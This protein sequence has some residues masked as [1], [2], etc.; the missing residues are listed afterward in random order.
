[1]TVVRSFLPWYREGFPAGIASDPVV[2]SGRAGLP[3]RFGLRNTAHEQQLPVHLA[4]PADVKGLDPRMIGRTEPYDGCADFEPGYL[5][6]VEFASP[7]LPWRFSPHAARAVT[8]ADPER[9][10]ES[11]T[12][13]RLKPWLALIV[14]ASDRAELS[15]AAPG[16]LPALVTSAELLPPAGESWAWAHVQVTTGSGE[17]LAEAIRDPTRAVARLVCPTR[18]ESLV[19]YSA[20]VVPTYEGGRAVLGLSVGSDPLA[21]SWPETGE[22]TLPVYFQWSFSTGELGTFETLARRLRP[23]SAPRESSGTPIDTGVPGWTITPTPGRR[24]TMQGAL[25]PLE[26]NEPAADPGL[27]DELRDAVSTHDV[28]PTLSPPIYGQDYCGGTTAVSPAGVRWLDQLNADPRRRLAAGLAAWAVVS[29]QEELA[30]EAWQQ[31]SAAGIDARRQNAAVLGDTI[32]DAIANRH[33]SSTLP[34]TLLRLARS[35]GPLPAGGPSLVRAATL[36]E[37]ATSA[38]TTFAPVFGQPAYEFLRGTSPEWLLPGV[39][40]VPDDSVVVLRSNPAFVE[41]F[42]VGLNHALAQELVWRGYPLART[43]TMFD[44]FW[45]SSS[46]GSLGSIADWP[47]DSELGE[48]VQDADQLALLVRGQLLRRFPTSE[49]YLAKTTSSGT[50]QRVNPSLRGRLTADCAFVGFSLSLEDVLEPSSAGAAGWHV[51]IEESVTHTRFGVDDAAD[52]PVPLASWQDL[53]WGHPHFD[54]GGRHLGI[55]GP[56]LGVTRNLTQ[57]SAERATWGA[58]SGHMACLLQQPAFRIRVP[59]GLWLQPVEDD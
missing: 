17:P 31:L 22:V 15:E 4:G 45:A 54:G 42:L 39:A 8:V 53:E 49:V 25:R 32:T 51:V 9:P 59:V 40:Q 34:A 55:D 33:V 57:S 18:L 24:T 7:D 2:G 50:E 1:M 38:T 52:Q 26:S 6:Y 28:G 14:V 44:G 16:Q 30:D 5:A 41:A 21:P 20:F 37:A 46:Q 19:R 10:G 11:T 48:H 23:R 56:L 43:T 58:S 13:T 29:A 27:A 35:G 47:P 36:R 3:A 12:G